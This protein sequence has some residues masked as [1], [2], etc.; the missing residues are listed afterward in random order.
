MPAMLKIR[1]LEAVRTG[2]DDILFEVCLPIKVVRYFRLLYHFCT[3]SDFCTTFVQ[4]PKKVRHRRYCGSMY[5]PTLEKRKL[6][7]EYMKDLK[8]RQVNDSTMKFFSAVKFFK[9]QPEVCPDTER[10][11]IQWY[12]ELEID[13]TYMHML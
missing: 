6:W 13:I 9:C 5:F 4:M 10:L 8:S 11:H 7:S 1:T 2:D 12:A 3:A